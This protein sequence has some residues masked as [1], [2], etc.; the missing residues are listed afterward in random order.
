MNSELDFAIATDGLTLK[1]NEIKT[2]SNIIKTALDDINEAR[3]SLSS[4]ISANKDKFD[5]RL[6]DVL[7]KISEI[8]EIIDSYS[9]VAIEVA[10]RVEQVENKIASA[11]DNVTND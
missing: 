9:N 10:G 6:R 5:N 7:P 1:G 8:T 2:Q 3:S 11:I 4:W